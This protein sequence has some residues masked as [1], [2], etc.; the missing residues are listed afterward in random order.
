MNDGRRPT[1]FEDKS[2]TWRAAAIEQRMATVELGREAGEE[3]HAPLADLA[4]NDRER[5]ER[6]HLAPPGLP[7][8]PRK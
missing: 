2:A 1:R 3:P 5:D 7:T 4:A 8:L 6:S